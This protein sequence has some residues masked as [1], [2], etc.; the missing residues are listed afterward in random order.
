MRIICTTSN[1]YAHLIPIFTYLF[2]RSMPG[3]EVTI[4]GYDPPT[5]PLPDNFTFV[6]MGKQG[7]V[8]EWS[9]D[10]R[11][12][13]EAMEDDWLLWC[14]D[15]TFIKSWDE[16]KALT[17]FAMMSANVGRID[18]TKD[19]SKRLHVV[20]N[21]VLFSLPNT[22]YRLS[23]QPSLWNKK[24]LLQYLTDGLDPWSFE[25]QDAHDPK[26]QVVGLVEYP[27]RHNEGVRKHDP[28]ALDLNGFPEEVV[29]HIKTLL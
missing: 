25:R 24:F 2:N 12:Y 9:T 26:W 1:A 17:A 5:C 29:D 18:L 7:D 23:T 10:I 11:R 15:D 8:S 4:L 16:E 14:M 3:Y 21:G 20:D 28:H 27:M 13:V 22:N 6:S 19:V